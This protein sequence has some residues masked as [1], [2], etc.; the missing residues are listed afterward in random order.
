MFK[1]KLLSFLILSIVFSSFLGFVALNNAQAQ[2]LD[3]VRD[4]I[5]DSTEYKEVQNKTYGT[6][7]SGVKVQNVVAAVINTFLGLLGVIFI[8]LIIY[9]GFLWMTAGGNEDQVG[10]A[11]KWLTNSIIGIIIIVAAYAIAQFVIESVI[12]AA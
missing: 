3:T 8:I 12:N 10:K 4:N 1:K 6:N 11:K 7:A 5:F 9:A 2:N